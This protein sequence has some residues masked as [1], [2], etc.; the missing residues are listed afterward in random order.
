M[1]CRVVVCLGPEDLETEMLFA[2]MPGH[3]RSAE[4]GVLWVVGEDGW[5]SSR[6]LHEVARFFFEHFDSIMMSAHIYN[7]MHIILNIYIY[8]FFFFQ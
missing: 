8:I 5:V 1:P 3:S 2:E 6:K 4:V 7:Y